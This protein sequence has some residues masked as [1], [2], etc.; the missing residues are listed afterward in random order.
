MIRA[1]HTFPRGFLWGTGTSS[2]QVEGDN[3]W[4][5]WWDWEQQEG[6]IVQGQRSGKACDWWG[7]RWAEDFDRAAQAGQNAHRLSI[8]WSR[9]EP[10]PGR[11]DTSALE[12]Y[13]SMLMGAKER[14]LTPIVT[15]HHFTNPRWLMEQGGWLADSTPARFASYVQKAV[16]GLHDLADIW[17]TINEPNVYAYAC[18][19]AGVFPPG[20]KDLGKTFEVMASL[21][22]GHAMAYQTIHEIQPHAMVGLAHHYRG[23]DPL[24]AW[25]PLERFLASFRSRIFNTLI[26]RALHDGRLRIPGKSLRIPEAART[27]DFFGL[28]SYT[29]EAVTFDPRARR[30]MFGRSGYPPDAD[31]SPSGFIANNPGGFWRALVWARRFDLPILVTENGV[32]DAEDRIR[33]RYLALHLRQL[34]R[35]V[36]FNWDVRGYI[37]WSLVDNFE[38]ERGWTQR[39][40]LWELDVDTQER[41]KRRSADFYAEICRANGLSSEM[42][43]RY[44]PEAVAMV[45]PRRGPGQ[46]A[47]EPPA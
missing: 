41:R 38:W 25:N 21:V 5:E 13:R 10:E 29:T 2:H 18:Y 9:L 20:V 7:G 23:M 37:H 27:Q 17:V 30:E 16:A 31:L 36:N 42:V 15:L 33:P 12:R 35:A 24:H 4:N 11:W 39:F 34:W 32:E 28:N 6:R 43:E 26:A 44:A 19:A 46:L 22:R 47:F 45:F 1:F 8:E 3:R 14:G 40:G